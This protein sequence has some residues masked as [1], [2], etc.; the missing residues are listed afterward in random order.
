MC[1]HGNEKEALVL[2][3]GTPDDRRPNGFLCDTVVF[4]G[5][6]LSPFPDIMFPIMMPVAQNECLSQN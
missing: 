2:G 6:K 1:V 3:T 5:F 4:P